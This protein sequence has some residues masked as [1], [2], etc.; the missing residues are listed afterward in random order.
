MLTA[1]SDDFYEI[2]E[3]PRQRP[4]VSLC[5]WK[6]AAPLADLPRPCYNEQYIGEGIYRGG[7]VPP[8]VFT[9]ISSHVFDKI[10]HT[11]RRGDKT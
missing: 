6:P 10:G 1:A 5:F 11:N 8:G 4:G 2:A 9:G 3:T 7:S